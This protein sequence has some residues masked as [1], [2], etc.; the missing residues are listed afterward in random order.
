MENKLIESLL[1]AEI[2]TKKEGGLS[3]EIE[4]GWVSK[5]ELK[6]ILKFPYSFMVLSSTTATTPKQRLR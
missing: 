3:D 5:R 2:G 1:R 4:K 6:S